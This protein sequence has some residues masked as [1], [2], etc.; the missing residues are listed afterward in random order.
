MNDTLFEKIAALP[1]GQRGQRQIID[2]ADTLLAISEYMREQ[3]KYYIL[4]RTVGKTT[5]HYEYLA[6]DDNGMFRWSGEFDDAWI[7][8]T[9]AHA[10]EE[11]RL[12]AKNEAELLPIRLLVGGVAN[13]VI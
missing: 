5:L 8:K 10:E 2:R 6:V 4:R 12:A 9:R 11:N 1:E 3:P 7:Y 13:D